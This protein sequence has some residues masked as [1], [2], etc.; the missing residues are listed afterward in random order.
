AAKDA[1]VP[2]DATFLRRFYDRVV[3]GITDRFDGPAMLPLIAP[4][5]F[6]AING[7]SDPRTPLPGLELCAAAA[8]AAYHAAGADENF[9]L[10][11]QPKTGHKVNP[12]SLQA[13]REW[14]A[15]QLKPASP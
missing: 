4:R 10:T 1:G 6:L 12:A 7:D 3:P 2:A 11:I 8:R 15:K 13:A 14:L 5:P 9:L